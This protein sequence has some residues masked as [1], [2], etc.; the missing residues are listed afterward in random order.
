MQGFTNAGSDLTSGNTPYW[1]AQQYPVAPVFGLVAN[2]AHKGPWGTAAAAAQFTASISGT[3]LTVTAI[4]SGTLA[5][6]HEI[7]L[8]D[9]SNFPTT[10][11][12]Y[13]IIGQTSG[14]TGS[15]GTYNLNASPGTVASTSMFATVTTL[16]SQ[17]FL[18]AVPQNTPLTST[19]RAAQQISAENTIFRVQSANTANNVFTVQSW[20]TT[21]YAGVAGTGNGF[22]QG[23][24]KLYLT[25]SDQL[26]SV[27]NV[28]YANGGIIRT[29]PTALQLQA[30]DGSFLIGNNLTYGRVYG[31][32]QYDA[33]ITPAAANTAYAYPI[34]GAS[35]V[36]DYSNIATTS[37]TSRI[38]PG[39][40]GMYKIQFSV[41]IDNADNTSDHTAYFW[42]RKN[43][44]DVPNSMGRIHVA[45]SQE[46]IGGWDNMIQSANTTDYWELMYAV[47]DTNV[48]FP[49]Y[50][51]TGFGPGTA[52]IFI[53]LVPIG[54]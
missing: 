41:Q 19:S 3:T 21:L 34:A 49:F 38:T 53:T 22:V 16:G 39:A 48:T 17:F 20:P 54:A 29:G 14:T 47:S 25:I 44:T 37:N 15:T 28:F 12:A 10:T 33:T 52:S 51:A 6:G 13:Q 35:G 4:S 40:A 30:T 27:H 5:L 1:T 8:S 24:N 7:R 26:T 32:W 46:T 50:A 31:Q 36:T 42:W 23:T 9:G 45:R 2:Q 11:N 43:G 18:N